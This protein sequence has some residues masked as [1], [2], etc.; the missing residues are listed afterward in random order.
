[1]GVA[2]PCRSGVPLLVVLDAIA[3]GACKAGVAA[4]TASGRNGRAAEQGDEVDEALGGM[5]ARMDMPPHAHAVPVGRG[6][7]FAAYPRC[8]ADLRPRGRLREVNACAIR[9]SRL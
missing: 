6:H 2:Y 7:R 8:S 9:A 5:V 4:H 3:T 1:M